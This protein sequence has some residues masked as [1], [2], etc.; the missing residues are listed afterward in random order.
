MRSARRQ[1]SLVLLSSA[2]LTTI[3]EHG[4]SITPS[5][6]HCLK[7]APVEHLRNVH[8]ATILRRAFRSAL[9]TSLPGRALFSS[10][11]S[12]TG[13]SFRDAL[14]LLDTL[15]TNQQVVKS[16]SASG[17]NANEAAIPEMREWLR[18]AGYTTND[19]ADHQRFIHV[20][21][22]KGK[23]S[24]CAMVESILLQFR[25]GQKNK[26]GKIGMYT[27][28]HLVSVT[29]RIRIDGLP[30]SQRT[31]ARYFFEI[32]DRLN[33]ANQQGDIESTKPSYFRYLT[34][35]ALHAFKQEGVET[36]IIE[37]GIGGEYDST[38]ILPRDAVTTTA[39]TS[40]GLD[41][42]E[43][44]GVKIEDIAWH[45]SGIMKDRVKVFTVKQ[46]PGAQAILE[47]RASAKGASLVLVE[48]IS[49]LQDI[50]LGLE[51]DFQKENA[52][53]AVSVAA[54]HLNEL[55]VDVSLPVP[56][57]TLPG[58]FTTGLETV[59]W[60]GRCQVIQD[61]NI[62]W[63]LDGAHTEESIRA[64]AIWYHGCLVK[65]HSGLEPPI[66]TMLMFNQTDRNGAALLRQLM[67]A[68]YTCRNAGSLGVFYPRNPPLA[69]G[70]R[71]LG[72]SIFTYAAFPASSPSR[73]GEQTR[74]LT[75]QERL[76]SVYQSLDGNALY[77]PYA[78]VA[79]AVELAQRVSRGDERLLVLV[80]GSL[81]LVGGVLQSL[82]IGK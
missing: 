13:R 49:T 41:H 17:R 66:A 37:C 22:T 11:P 77:M 14:A 21:G 9:L 10:Q 8:M 15:Q 51:G 55:A 52:A 6:A 30:I 24:V 57:N 31:F 33:A 40:L 19:F 70:S 3:A 20:A 46:V 78:T 34:I 35:L 25:S 42:V 26:I 82:N 23:G 68:L 4:V 28:P 56:V 39:I 27:S 43:M 63:C 60:P 5:I 76:G 81:Y 7:Q 16:I 48:P 47:Q 12:F 2:S 18:R 54:S 29:E 32:W 72:S 64:A 73:Q 53:L 71:R 50:K 58:E 67:T 38:N 61:G 59:D 36:A 62:T 65:A 1:G 45:K 75:A 80:T 74:D 44:L 79:E 69:G